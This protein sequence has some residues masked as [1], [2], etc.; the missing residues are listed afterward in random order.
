MSMNKKN[1]M[2][3]VLAVLVVAG[4]GFWIKVNKTDP[5]SYYVVYLTTG[6][7]YVGKLATFPAWELKDSYILATAKDS[8]DPNKSN[9]QL[10]P[11]SEALWAPEYM[12]LN[13]KNVVF[14]GPIL[15][16]SKIGEALAAKTK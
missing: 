1:V 9:F 8:T 10:N 5:K 11:I 2:L 6:E 15:P 7:V 4:V 13:R 3:I 14:Y 16:T 12:R